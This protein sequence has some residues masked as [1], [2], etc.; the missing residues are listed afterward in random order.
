[1]LIWSIYTLVPIILWQEW[2]NA[3]FSFY[4]LELNPA[5]IIMTIFPIDVIKTDSEYKSGVQAE[6]IN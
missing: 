6:T 1:M 3:S 2:K 5:S 4:H